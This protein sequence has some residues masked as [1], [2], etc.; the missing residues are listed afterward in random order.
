MTSCM[1]TCR[2]VPCHAM[3]ARDATRREGTRLDV[4]WRDVERH[5]TSYRLRCI[6]SHLPL[7]TSTASYRAVPYHL[8]FTVSC[9]VLHTVRSHD[10]KLYPALLEGPGE[11]LRRVP[12]GARR[13]GP[14]IG[15]R[16]EVFYCQL[17]RA[18]VQ[19]YTHMPFE[20]AL[21]RPR[22]VSR[23]PAGPGPKPQAC[24]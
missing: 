1:I 20:S 23:E 5:I 8:A 18:S 17:H 21:A 15:Q 6:S 12:A 19:G 11:T 4:M 14:G 24:M 22:P 7:H 2:A 9:V 13:H 16:T 10:A 3:P